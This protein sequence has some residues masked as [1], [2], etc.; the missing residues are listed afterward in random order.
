MLFLKTRPEV[1]ENPVDITARAPRYTS[2][3]YITINGFSGRALLRNISYGG[4]CME[5]RTYVAITPGEYYTMCLLPEPSINL[6]PFEM[7][8]EVRWIRST[9]TKFSAGFLISK[10]PADRS[11]EKYFNYIK[12]QNSIVA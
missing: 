8:V 1:K 10:F 7:T 12:A 2:V 4:F 6:R 5:S 11:F 9:E 3:A